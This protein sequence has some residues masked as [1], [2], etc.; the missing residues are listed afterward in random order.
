MLIVGYKGG[1][2]FEFLL[3]VVMWELGYKVFLVIKCWY[4]EVEMGYKG[5]G[6]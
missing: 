2:V 3:V 4:E 6:L 1:S 5:G